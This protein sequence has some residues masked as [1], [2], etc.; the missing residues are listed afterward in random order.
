MSE[1]QRRKVLVVEDE[2]ALRLLCRVNLELD[3]FDVVEAASLREA[4]ERLAAS[5]VDVVLLDLHLGGESGEPL[6]GECRARSPRI[7]VAVVSG[8]ADP[9]RANA[10]GADAV[11]PKPF[12]IGELTATVRALASA[13]LGAG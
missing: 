9:P 10:A 5:A 2:A 4:R 12:E 8:S 7:P 1:E 11:L 6:V 3:G 13:V